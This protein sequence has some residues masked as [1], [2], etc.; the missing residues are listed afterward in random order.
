MFLKMLQLEQRTN[1][2]FTEITVAKYIPKEMSMRQRRLVRRRKPMV[3]YKNI[4]KMKV[5]GKHYLL[6]VRESS[7]SI[8]YLLS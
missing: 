4:E 5:I 3:R 1:G 2:D 8:D 6:G 7:D